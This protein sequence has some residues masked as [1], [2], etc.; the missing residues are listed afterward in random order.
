[1]HL[2]DSGARGTSASRNRGST[3]SV[4][5]VSPTN[6]TKNRALWIGLESSQV[7]DSLGTD[8][9]RIS[10]SVQFP[11][12]GGTSQARKAT[13]FA[14]VIATFRLAKKPLKD[15]GLAVSKK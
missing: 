6:S 15:A 10:Q 12:Q 8:Q 5:R 7:A 9:T 13:Q 2:A 11:L 14:Q 3:P 4:F 1:M